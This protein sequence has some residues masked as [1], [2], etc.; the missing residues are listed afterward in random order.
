MKRFLIHE[1]GIHLIDVFRFLLGEVRSVYAD[2]TKLN[3]V[4]AGEDSGTVLFNFV[5]S[6]TKVSG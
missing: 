4:I 3:P 1:T 5:G 2:L 6:Q